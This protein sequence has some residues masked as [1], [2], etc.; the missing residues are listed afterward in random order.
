[1]DI[2]APLPEELSAVISAL[3]SKK[4]AQ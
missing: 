2:T 1:V 3:E 4:A